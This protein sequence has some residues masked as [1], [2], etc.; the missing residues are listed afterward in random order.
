MKNDIH[1]LGL[2]LDSRVKLIITESWEEQRVLETMAA[3]AVKRARTWFTWDHVDGLQR[4]GFGEEIED[5]DTCDPE[6]ALQCVRRDSQQSIYVF[7]DLHPFLENPKVVRLLKLVAMN[8]DPHAPTIMLVSHQIKLA[9]ELSRLAARVELSMPSDEQLSAIIRE[10][11]AVWTEQNKG[12]KV[13]TDS[14]TLEQVVRN[15]RGTTHEEA[16]RLARKLIADDGAITQEDVPALNKAKF[17]LLDMQ[18]VLS[19]EQNTAHFAEV[20]GL[21]HFKRWL[22]ERQAAFLGAGQ[23]E[24]APRG[25]ML[26]GVQGAGK[27]LAAKAVAGVWGLPLLRLDF[28]ALYNKY[29]GETEKN[30][31]E[32]LQMADCM[33]PCVLWIDEIEKGLAPDSG[34][35]GVSRRLLGTLLTWMSERNTRVFL[36][37]TAN[38]V[39]QLPPELIRK[40]RLDELFFI[41]LPDSSVRE[42]ILRIHLQK[43]GLSIEGFDVPALSLACDGF[44]GAEIEQA[45][46]AAV[47]AASARGQS[48][49]DAHLQ[50]AMSQ[51]SPLSVV[52]AER[53]QALRAWG[54]DRAVMAG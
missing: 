23:I 49:T 21:H 18:G 27:S 6:K 2:L 9:P 41:D 5:A 37:A 39:S 52:M 32:A 13:R 17:S 7:C 29:I 14:R 11:A 53:L 38:D 51:T 34:D 26:V 16:R 48:V 8:A 31:R 33:E 44:S 28:A 54:R 50:G 20:G 15:L 4:L 43:R 46:V 12:L 1:D 36:V 22:M 19:F 3:L 35:Q 47:Y 24:D 42:D 10:E 45:V 40:G 25:V 30:L